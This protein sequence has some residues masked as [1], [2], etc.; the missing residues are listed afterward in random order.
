MPR[1]TTLKPRLAPAKVRDLRMVDPT[2]RQRGR[3]W[4]DRRA[5]WFRKHPLCVMCESQGRVTAA[6][7]LD[8]VVPLWEG[9][10]DDDT[11]FQ[12]L[13]ADCHKAKTAEEATRRTGGGGS[14]FGSL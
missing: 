9:G 2:Q 11:N 13:C 3:T 4:M 5:A 6:T 14:K 7:Q 8:H 1:L 12:S 10:S